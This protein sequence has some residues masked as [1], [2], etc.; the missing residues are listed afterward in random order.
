MDRTRAS[1]KPDP[2][3]RSR[4]KAPSKAPSTQR[5][6]QTR[7]KL[8][9]AAREI[10]S[11]AAFSDVRITDITAAAGVASGTFYTYFDSKEEIFRE[12]A[13]QVLQEMSEA[14]RGR[15]RERHQTIAER[16]EA[17]TRSY[18]ACVR[19]NR[20]IARSIEELLSREPGVGE[21][22]HRALGVGV[23]RIE[24][25]I[26]R[27]QERGICPPGVDPW[28]TA[29]SLHAMNVSVAYDHLVYRDAPEETE[30]LLKA[31]TRVWCSTLGI[32]D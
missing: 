25:W 16:V 10:F 31:T 21:A 6:R 22:R 32:T 1:S 17:N 29:L 13:G 3:S 28:P 12:I 19:A 20:Q 2:S 8:V 9:A 24:A 18:F 14:F 4:R 11:R 23:Q 5:G 30:S 15:G 7:D 26:R 27:L